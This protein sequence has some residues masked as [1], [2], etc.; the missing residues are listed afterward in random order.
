MLFTICVLADWPWIAI[1][2][3]VISL[4]A[5][6]VTVVPDAV[7]LLFPS[8]L[9]VRER[10]SDPSSINPPRSSIVALKDS[11]IEKVAEATSRSLPWRTRALS[12][13]EPSNR[14]SAVR[15]IVFPAPVSPVRTL[16]PLLSSSELE[17]MI[18]KLRIEI[19]SR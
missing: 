9:T 19:S 13:F 12:D 16:S 4:S 17:S 11:G 10:I 15:I 7:A 1:S 6:A 18:P 14:E 3:S 5:E 8:L 2:G